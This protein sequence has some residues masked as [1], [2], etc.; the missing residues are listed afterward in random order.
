MELSRLV[1]FLYLIAVIS[2][3]RGQVDCP[4]FT[5]GLLGST[6]AATATGLVRAAFANSAGESSPLAITVQVHASRT[7]CLRSG[8]TRNTYSGVSVVVNYT[9]SGGSN[10]LCN[11]NPTNSQF[12][13]ECVSSPS[14]EWAAS[15]IGSTENIIT[16]PPT[17]NFATTLRRDCGVCISPARDQFGS[18]TNNEQHCGG[19]WSSSIHAHPY[20]YSYSHQY[21][22]RSK[23]FSPKT[24][25][26]KKM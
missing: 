1:M 25:P 17:G 18:I 12:D 14:L 6:T 15:V 11:G 8:R 10:P 9:C 5:D 23:K 20:T 21:V 2:F 13:F 4:E 24:H 16:T 26:I 19:K 3:A 22:T 7:V